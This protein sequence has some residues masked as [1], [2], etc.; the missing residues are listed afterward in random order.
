VTERV[1][2]ALRDEPKRFAF[3]EQDALPP[4]AHPCRPKKEREDGKVA[5]YAAGEP[6]ARADLSR[7][8]SIRFAAFAVKLRL[9][10]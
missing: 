8:A 1:T 7:S 4:A 10:T 3:M 9:S 2:K 5:G 6:S